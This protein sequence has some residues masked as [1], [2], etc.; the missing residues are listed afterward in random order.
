MGFVERVDERI[1][2]QWAVDRAWQRFTDA[3]ILIA[4]RVMMGETTSQIAQELSITR[5]AVEASLVTMR[6][7]FDEE[8]GG[9][10]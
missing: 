4:Q 10:D 3:E 8:P 6:R 5:Q 2:A 9:M 7:K 1:D